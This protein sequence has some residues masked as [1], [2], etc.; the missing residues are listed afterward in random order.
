MAKDEGSTKDARHLPANAAPRAWVMVFERESSRLVPLPEAGELTL[1]RGDY[2]GLVLR[3]AGVSRQHARF[4]VEL[5][6]VRVTDLGSQNGTRVNGQPIRASRVL[7]AGDE[8]QVG[9]AVLVFHASSERASTGV[10]DRAAFRAQVETEL[11]RGKKYVRPVTVGFALLE[12]ATDRMRLQVH[13]EPWLRRTEPVCLSDEGLLWLAP[14]LS[15]EELETRASDLLRICQTLHTEARLGLATFPDD[16]T[17][18]DALV[19][20]ARESARAAGSGKIQPA[21]AAFKEWKL[22]TQ[23]IWLADT[24]MLRLYGLL[25]RLA[26]SD[27]PVLVTGETGTGKELAATALHHASKRRDQRLMVLNCAALPETL[28]EAE[29]FGNE[30]GAFTGAVAARAGALETA[31]GGTVFLD[32]VGE[33]PLAI[34]AKLLRALETKKVT[35][36]GDTRERAVDFRVVAA[37]HR[38][39]ENEVRAGRFREDL[40][41]RLSAATLHLPP[42]RDRKRELVLL[43][44]AF[45]TRAGL[46]SGRVQTLSPAAVQLLAH[47]TWPGNVRELRNVVDY[48]AATV[49]DE[50]I[51]PW[52]LQERLGSGPLS[53][54]SPALFSTEPSEAS[55][56]ALAD[57]VRE[58]ERARMHSALQRHRWNQTRAAQALGVPLRTFVTKMTQYGLRETRQA[59]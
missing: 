40:Y 2:C 14:E 24:V 17:R 31:D 47:H 44:R 10:L 55:F 26:A 50:V 41:F 53:A 54:A 21:G 42:L 51:E 38:T 57:E 45:L 25:E 18:A 13:L 23:T 1:G 6:Q 52:H 19:A 46:S 8:L 35:R 59:D 30:R 48:V 16:E 9:D 56:R 43:A 12:N 15:A 49:T 37:T 29:L 32:E 58:L 7:H 11:E 34:Q 3:D 4:E 20:A 33:L 28:A 22:G 27:L 39:L 5:G 36:V